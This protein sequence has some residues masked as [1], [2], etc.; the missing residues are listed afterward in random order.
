MKIKVLFIVTS[1]WAYGELSIAMQFA[2]RIGEYEPVFLAPL[3]MQQII[4]RS[5]YAF[6]PLYIH[7]H[8]VNS[9]IL[10]SILN[11]KDFKLIIL[12]DILN[13]L[14]CEK[15][16]GLTMTNLSGFQ[17]K[18]GGFDLYLI[19]EISRK[20]D[21]YGFQNKKVSYEDLNIDF[22]ILSSPILPI[23]CGSDSSNSFARRSNP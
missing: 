6:F 20:M 11:D 19:S 7:Q 22:T 17:G 23:G 8:K 10:S 5:G 2:K 1:Y 18:I 21:T 4:V 15:S 12:S 16:Y 9:V 14:Y 13:F 3:N